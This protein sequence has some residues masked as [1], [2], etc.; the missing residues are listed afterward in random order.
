M[1]DR[2]LIRDRGQKRLTLIIAGVRQFVFEARQVV[3]R[4]SSPLGTNQILFLKL[5]K[6]VIDDA[7]KRE[8]CEKA[9][10]SQRTVIDVAL[11]FPARLPRVKIQVEKDQCSKW[12]FLHL[13]TRWLKGLFVRTL[14]NKNRIV[15]V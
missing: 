9:H 15:K 2:S 4:C 11:E 10:L 7:I 3:V 14:Y 1:G 6:V 12:Q 13:C 5:L 8:A